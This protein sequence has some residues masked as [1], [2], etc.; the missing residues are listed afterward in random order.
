MKK[1][2]SLFTFIVFCIYANAQT[3]FTYMPRQPKPGDAITITYDPAGTKLKE[4]LWIE[5]V[6]YLME[7]TQPLAVEVPLKLQ[8]GRWVGSVKTNDTTKAVFFNFLNDNNS[9]R[10]RNGY[11]IQ[12]YRNGSVVAGSYSAYAMAFTDYG[13][14]WGL[15]RNDLIAKEYFEKEFAINNG[16]KKNAPISYINLMAR[17][18]K[19][20]DKAIAFAEAEK[21]MK[22]ASTTE[23]EMNG[24]SFMYEQAKEADKSRLVK[25]LMKQKFPNGDWKKM[26]ALNKFYNADTAAKR[27]ALYQSLLAFKPD[28]KNEDNYK[29]VVAMGYMKENNWDKFK[30]WTGKV[31]NKN[32][33]AN[34]YNE[35]AWKLSGESI[36]GKAGDLVYAKELSGKSLQYTKAGISNGQDK[37]GYMTEKAWKKSEL[38]TFGNFQDT[39]ALI[40]Y[41]LNELDDAYNNQKAA[42]E[43][44][45]GVNK[46]INERYA[47]Y[48]E[49]VKG[50]DEA[51]TLI[52]KF[53]IEG[54][55]SG[56]MKE[57]LKKMYLSKNHSPSEWETFAAG[58]QKAYREKRYEEI[59]ASMIR[60]DA[61][62]FKLANLEGNTV[63]L[64][65]LK[66]KVV[67]VDFWATWCGPCK[68]SFP[69]MQ[70]AVNKY[71]D[72]PNVVFVFVDTWENDLPEKVKTKVTDFIT[73]NKY[74][75]NVLYDFDNQTVSDF[76]VEG[77]P[78][79]FILDKNNNIRFKAVGYNG[80]AE[81]LNEELQSMIQL[82]TEG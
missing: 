45:N 72:D 53:M 29:T 20:G 63:S 37:P 18:K 17:S 11:G 46:E 19:P 62:K 5:A 51:M 3:N 74:T 40:A 1:I 24:I 21:M 12:L 32:S 44:M 25:E 80:S 26:E 58:L 4:E 81:E 76:Q 16:N 6:A 41:K 49:K 38:Q 22:D 65:Q 31:K 13:W 50:Q 28:E 10:S 56:P 69:G 47:V 60:E 55:A 75:F 42:A 79:K 7:G 35:A 34:I 64:E 33:L 14:I 57:Q 77:I 70:Q 71:K 68:A 9:D 78:T 30:E 52:E 43:S 82:A 8:N 48:T 54:K 15:K 59:K 36:E 39:Y 27:E 66:G 23:Q 61:P 67:V 73:K 2:S